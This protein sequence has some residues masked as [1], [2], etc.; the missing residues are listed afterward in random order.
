MVAIVAVHHTAP[1]YAHYTLF[2]YPLNSPIGIS[3]CPLTG[4]A[5]KIREVARRGYDVITH[6]TIRSNFH[7]AHPSPNMFVVDATAITKNGKN[8]TFHKKDLRS[9]SIDTI[10]DCGDDISIINSFGIDSKNSSQTIEDIKESKNALLPGQLLIVSI[11]GSGKNRQEQIEDFV[12]T[13]G[14]AVAG[15]ADILEA[16][17]SCPNVGDDQTFIY[18]DP[19][20]VHDICNAIHQEYSNIP[21]IVKVGL[22]EDVESMKAI[23]HAAYNGGARGIC[24]IN[25]IPV[26][27]VDAIGNPVFGQDRKISGLSGAALFDVALAFVQRAA[28]IINEE[29]LDLKLFATGGVTCWQ[30]FDQ[31]MAAGADIVQCATGALLNEKLAGDYHDNHTAR[32]HAQ[33]TDLIKRLFHIGAI[34][35]ENIL[36]KSGVVSPIYFDMRVTISHPTIL[37]QIAQ[38]LAQLVSCCTFDLICGVPYAALPIATGVAII[39]DYPMI[40]PR[41]ETKSH[42]TRKLIEGVYQKDMV[43]AVI[44]DVATTGSSILETIRVLEEHG[45]VV[46]DIFIVVDREQNAVNTMEEHGYHVHALF[47]ITE[48]LQTLLAEH[49]ITHKQ[50]ATVKQFCSANQIKA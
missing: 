30:Q 19:A 25:T 21:L 6:K 8:Y 16:N 14:L 24:G 9:L 46:R 10:A 2:G 33:R 38:Q 50:F 26:C 5:Q 42:G 13:A 45:L 37:K 20:L 15:G 1:T 11:Y 31:L 48:I 34:K 27:V 18:Q 29:N 35:L 39:G 32:N 40:M 43:C 4:T 7:A 28:K 22:F 23:F 36:L 17:F 47:T 41:K 3:A 49:L 44:E 12:K